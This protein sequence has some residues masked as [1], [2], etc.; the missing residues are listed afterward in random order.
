MVVLFGK[1]LSESN[2]IFVRE[3]LEYLHKIGLKFV[4]EEKYAKLLREQYH[5]QFSADTF[6]EY[7]EVKNQAE[8]V[9]SLGGDGTI[10]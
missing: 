7:G 8:V 10:L 2:A 1:T 5:M 4:I 6:K 3:I 9:F